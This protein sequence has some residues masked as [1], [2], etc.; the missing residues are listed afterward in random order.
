MS[1]EARYRT[2][3]DWL[4]RLREF[5]DQEQKVLLAL[6]NSQFNWRTRDR[7][8]EVMS[9]SDRAGLRIGGLGNQGACAP[10]L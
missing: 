8:L 1:A 6:S 5:S 10:V 9:N 3:L 7:L 4:K 2:D